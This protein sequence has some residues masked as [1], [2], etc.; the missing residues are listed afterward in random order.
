MI[1]RKVIHKKLIGRVN[2]H[3]RLILYH[4]IILQ[5]YC[6]IIKRKVVMTMNFNENNRDITE[7]YKELKEYNKILR[8]EERNKK[9]EIGIK[10]F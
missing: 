4:I 6:P 8:E 7:Q 2:N 10:N 9:L 5:L 3:T 1:L